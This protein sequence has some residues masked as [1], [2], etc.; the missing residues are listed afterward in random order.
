MLNKKKSALPV[1]G[2]VAGTIAGV[3]AVAAGAIW[4]YKRYIASLIISCEEFSPCDE[5]KMCKECACCGKYADEC[6]AQGDCLLEGF[7]EFEAEEFEN[8]VEVV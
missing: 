1:V 7:G 8:A 3:T 5:F 2:I 4:L 6:Y